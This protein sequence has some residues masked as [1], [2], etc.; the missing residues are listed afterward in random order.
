MLRPILALI[1]AQ[2]QKSGNSN[3]LTQIRFF[4]FINFSAHLD[5]MPVLFLISFSLHILVFFKSAL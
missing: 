5:D 3:V 1:M 4:L 2:F